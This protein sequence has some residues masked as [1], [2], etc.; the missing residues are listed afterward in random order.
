MS[1]RVLVFGGSGFIGSNTIE[2]LISSGY[3]VLNCDIRQPYRFSGHEHETIDINDYNQTGF[4]GWIWEDS[5]PVHGQ[6]EG[7]FAKMM[8]GEILK[9]S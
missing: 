5:G 9:P 7:K 4:G 1:S 8:N 6:Y 3:D 2:M